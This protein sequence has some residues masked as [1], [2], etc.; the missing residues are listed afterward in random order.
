VSGGNTWGSLG[1]T[2]ATGAV[3]WDFGIIFTWDQTDLK[4]IETILG[5]KPVASG[6][7]ES[8]DL[9]PRYHYF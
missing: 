4:N 1:L 7:G 8:I 5:G 3:F 6:L 2:L 9:G